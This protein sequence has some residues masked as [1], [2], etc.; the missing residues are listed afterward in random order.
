[1]PELV[2]IPVPRPPA[3]RSSTLSFPLLDPVKDFGIRPRYAKQAPHITLLG[4]R[5]GPVATSSRP[6]QPIAPRADDPLDARRLHCRLD[7]IARVLDDLPAQARRMAHWQARRDA[8]LAQE[9]QASERGQ[10]HQESAPLSTIPTRGPS[11]SNG[12]AARKRFHRF[13]PMRP[14]RPPGWRRK[15]NHDIFEV[16][17]EVHGLAVRARERRDS[18]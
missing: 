8:W 13:S 4:N 10:S 6:L 9:R 17:N 7:A 3:G 12:G 14:G 15:P 1:M 5:D 2:H 16:L 18:S 11:R